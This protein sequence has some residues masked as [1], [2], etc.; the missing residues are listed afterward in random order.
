MM[1]AIVLEKERKELTE[2]GKNKK[3]R[4][5][6]TTIKAVSEALNS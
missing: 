6:K 1:D 5:S 3:S 2:E 4:G